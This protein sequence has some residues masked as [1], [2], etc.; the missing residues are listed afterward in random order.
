MNRSPL[1]TDVSPVVARKWYQHPMLLF[2]LILPMIAVGV[3]LSFVVTA[4]KNRDSMVRD[5]WYMDGKALQHDLSLDQAAY[6]MAITAQGRITGN[7]LTLTL[8]S[9]QRMEPALNPPTLSLILSHNTV[10]ARDRT[11]SLQ[12]QA[13]GQYRGSWP[14]DLAGKYF[15]DL[16]GQ[17]W[18]LRQHTQLPLTAFELQPLTVF[19]QEGRNGGYV[20]SSR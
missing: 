2:M 17:G 11:I 6:R 8:S 4:F 13:D 10:P 18:R 14:A 1:S 7:Q 5:N 3:S 19:A 20:S 16:E 15:M 9:P 12:R